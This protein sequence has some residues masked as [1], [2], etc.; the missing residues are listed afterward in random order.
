MYFG[1]IF[2][3]NKVNFITGD[4]T[5]PPYFAAYPL[6]DCQINKICL[7]VDP[8]A[9]DYAVPFFGFVTNCIPNRNNCVMGDKI[10]VSSY[11]S[12]VSS[13]KFCDLAYCTKKKPDVYPDLKRLPFS[14]YPMGEV[15]FMNKLKISK[16]KK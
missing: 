2:S 6:V 12:G 16:N 3:K 15:Q 13:T 9:V 10:H 4:K 8:M 1:G 11:E 5:C 7:S 14:P